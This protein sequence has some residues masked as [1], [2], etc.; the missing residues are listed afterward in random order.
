MNQMVLSLMMCHG[1][2]PSTFKVGV[3]KIKKR[4]NG[5]LLI[6]WYGNAGIHLRYSLWIMDQYLNRKL[7][8]KVE[9]Y[10]HLVYTQNQIAV[11]PL[12]ECALLIP[13][14]Q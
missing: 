1:L 8:S 14:A 5:V 7:K 6:N 12:S 2:T 9:R 3:K 10:N 11:A 13:L 4:I